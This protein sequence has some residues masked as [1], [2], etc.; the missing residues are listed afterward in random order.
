MFSG[1]DALFS[2]QEAIGRA[3]SD[4][5]RLDAALRS[6]ID[7]AARLRSQEAQGFRTLARIRLDAMV[8]DRVIDDLDTTERRAFEMIENNRRQIEGL[9]RRRD[10]AQASLGKAEAAKHD[11]DNSLAGAIDALDELRHRTAERIKS[12]AIWTAVKAAVDAAEKVAAN[13]DEKAS[14][15]EADLAAKRKPYEDDPI[16]MYLWRRKHGR[17]EDTSSALVKFCDRKVARL[18]GYQDASA[19]YAMLQEIPARLREHAKNKQ[20]DVDAARQ[21]VVA[22]ERAALVA[23]GVEKIEARVAA[24]QAA[25]RAAGEAVLKFT[26]ELQQIDAARA[27]ALGADDDAAWSRG[28]DVLAEALAREDLRTLYQEVVRTATKADDQAISSIS[29]ARERLQK[30]DSEVARIRSEIREMA[31][32]RSELEGARDRARLQGYDD[33]RGT[34]GGS[35]G[36]VIGQVIGAILQGAI[37]GRAIDNVLRDNYRAPR[38]RADLDF[39]GSADASSW[40]NPWGG[41]GVDTSGGGGD[42][43][44]GWRTG[45][46]F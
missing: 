44:T 11:H 26:A 1:R 42:G 22:I 4:E 6:A 32:R 40:P 12:D 29:A 38:R 27:E 17:A 41:G 46:G 35:G 33:P 5:G 23:D 14:L 18:V 43:G 37:Q 34:L 8:R 10:E 31:H 20:S 19:N 28:V 24:N 7:E 13:A 25:V 30:A 15:A 2:V 39:G 45:G 21:R 3:R 16:F 36:Q 9:G